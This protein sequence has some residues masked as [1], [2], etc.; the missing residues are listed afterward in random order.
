MRRRT[1]L[2]AVVGVLAAGFGCRH[3]GGKCD[4]GA[5]PADAVIGPPT[6]PYPTAPAPGLNPNAPVP[7]PPTGPTTSAPTTGGGVR[8]ETR[9]APATLPV[10]MPKR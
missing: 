5:H 10:P 2:T 8:V 1:F 7:I 4:C 3:V 9:T 6:P